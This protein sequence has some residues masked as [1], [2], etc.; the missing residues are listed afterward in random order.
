MCGGL[1][2][3]SLNC[4]VFR[5]KYNSSSKSRVSDERTICVCLSE[6]MYGKVRRVSV[7]G[8]CSAV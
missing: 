5:N 3:K 1:E 4:A 6:C 7:G 2:D 8:Q